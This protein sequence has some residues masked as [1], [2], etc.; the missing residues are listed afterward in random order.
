MSEIDPRWKKFKE[1][2]RKG[3]D[4]PTALR[5]CKMSAEAFR[6][7]LAG[8][9]KGDPR[10]V[11]LFEEIAEAEAEAVDRYV[12]RMERAADTGNFNATKFALQS[13]RPERFGTAGQMPPPPERPTVS[14]DDDAKK[15]I[16]ALTLKMIEEDPE[17]RAQLL[18]ALA[19]V[20][21]LQ[22]K[23]IQDAEIV[24]DK[25]KDASS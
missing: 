10:Y 20:P 18:K 9:Q 6:T 5:L 3:H 23:N 4:R 17:A 15:Q 24:V 14:T 1:Y 11:E 21:A 13:L 22:E 8:A 7:A 25:D 12:D 16:L 2:L 19:P